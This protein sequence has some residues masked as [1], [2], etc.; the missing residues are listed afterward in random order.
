MANARSDDVLREIRT[1]FDTGT[2]VGLSDAQLLERFAARRA[3]ASEASHA[4]DAAFAALVARHGPMV[5]GV[6]R[7]VLSSPDDAEDAF[8]ATFLVSPR[9]ADPCRGRTATALADRDGQRTALAGAETFTQAADQARAYAR[10][11]AL[12]GTARPRSAQGVRAPALGA[13][14]GPHC[15]NTVP[16]RPMTKFAS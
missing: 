14:D 1:L 13:I 15:D 2:A 10:G 9:R 8:Q 5:L 3:E 12:G 16:T 6:C 7:R 11:R 4:A